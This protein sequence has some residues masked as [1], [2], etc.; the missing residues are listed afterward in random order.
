MC[1]AAANSTRGLF[2]GGRTPTRQTDI[3]FITIATTGNAQDFG[4]LLQALSFGPGLASST[5]GILAGG[6]L[7]PANVNTIQY[8][9]IATTGNAIDFGD[10]T[11]ANANNGG[12][13]SNGHGGL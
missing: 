8:V 13:M 11:T 9:T 6:D 4:D 5:R 3:D 7:S 1:G 12:G 2:L 10:T